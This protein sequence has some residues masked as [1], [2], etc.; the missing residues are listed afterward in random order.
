MT[1]LLGSRGSKGNC[2]MAMKPDSS[3]GYVIN[4]TGPAGELSGREKK[5]GVGSSMNYAE[6][7]LAVQAATNAVSADRVSGDFSMN[8]EQTFLDQANH[9]LASAQRLR[10][11]AYLTS[12]SERAKPHITP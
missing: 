7:K 5:N 4:L 8:E 11:E 3:H 1:E 9:S 12:I 2:V 6:Y 10:T